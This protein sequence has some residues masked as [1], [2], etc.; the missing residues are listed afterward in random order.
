MAEGISAVFQ[1]QAD[2]ANPD[3]APQRPKHCHS[4]RSV[5]SGVRRHHRRC[6][7]LAAL[8]SDLWFFISSAARSRLSGGAGRHQILRRCAPQNDNAWSLP[9]IWLRRGAVFTPTAA[10][11]SKALRWLIQPVLWIVALAFLC[12]APVHAHEIGTTRVAVLFPENGTYDVEIVTD[13]ATL[14]DKLE[15][16]SGQP[17]PT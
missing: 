15:S 3:V 1:K 2:G 14:N 17:S 12:G 6:R 11:K 16:S 8:E 7:L 9:A 13:A 5:E 10:E 4:E